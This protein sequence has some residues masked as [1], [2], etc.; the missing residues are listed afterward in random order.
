MD[1]LERVWVQTSD[2]LYL[3]LSEKLVQTSSY[4]QHLPSCCDTSPLC[5]PFP[6]KS[7]HFLTKVIDTEGRDAEEVAGEDPELYAETCKLA[8]YLGCEEALE[9]LMGA[10]VTWAQRS[11][12]V[13]EEQEAWLRAAYPW[14][15]SYMQN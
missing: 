3:N 14:A 9:G 4:L 2:G 1:Y 11:V 8:D 6:S 15:A 5:L 13:S 7:I 12:E 10:L